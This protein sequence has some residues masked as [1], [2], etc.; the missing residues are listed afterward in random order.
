MPSPLQRIKAAFS[1]SELAAP[2]TPGGGDFVVYAGTDHKLHTLDS[3]GVDTALGGSTTS[4]GNDLAPSAGMTI[5]ANYSVVISQ[6]FEVVS[7]QTLDI[8]DGGILEII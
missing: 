5:P 4:V 8:G 1:M 2:S 3:S 7:G 6:R